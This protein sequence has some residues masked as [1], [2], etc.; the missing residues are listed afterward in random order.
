MTFIKNN[1]SSFLLLGSMLIGGIIGALWGPGAEILSPIAD[2]FL[3]LLYC[4]VVP[5]IFISLVSSI[6]NMENLRKLGKLLGIMLFIFV[7][8]QIFASLYMGAICAVFDPAKGA[9]IAMNEGVADLTSNSNFL[10]MFT[11]N[12]FSNLWSRKNLT[13]LIVFS[14]ITGVALVAI[15]EK[16]KSLIKIF[17]EGT[18]LIMKMIKYVMYLAPIGLC[19]YFAILVGQYGSELTGSLARAIIIYLIAAVAYY[20][21]SNLLFAFMGAGREGV[22]RYLRH[23]IPPTLTALGTCSSVATIPTTTQAANNM[24]ISPEVTN[25]CVPLGANLHKDGACLITMLKISFMCSV[26]GMNFLDPKIFLTAIMVSTLASMVMGA[27]PAGGYVGEIFII[28]AFNF[29]AVSIP[30]MVLIGTITD[31]P[32]TAINATGDLSCAMIVERF[33]NGK[34]WFKNK[35]GEAVAK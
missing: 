19:A 11:V 12:D 18:A 20:F 21:L 33:V 30:I 25:L 23:C 8:T 13:A 7:L 28:S 29:P 3:N 17:D 32:A 27:I 16:G 1:K 9:T 34:N 4:C 24:G 15:G 2:T 31:A 6:A 14:M 26:F 22:R 5:M 10:A 35:L